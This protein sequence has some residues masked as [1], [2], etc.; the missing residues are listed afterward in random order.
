MSLRIALRKKLVTTT[1]VPNGEMEILDEGDSWAL[2]YHNSI[3]KN[4]PFRM[5]TTFSKAFEL[6]ELM[7]QPEV[8]AFLARF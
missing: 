3:Y 4:S 2:V 1:T 7:R 8:T 5:P 6:S